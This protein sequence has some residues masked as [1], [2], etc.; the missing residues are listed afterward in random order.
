[1]RRYWNIWIF[2]SRSGTCLL[3]I[4]SNSSWIEIY[5]FSKC[6]SSRFKTVKFIIKYKMWFKNLRFWFSESG[7][8]IIWSC[9][10]V[11]RICKYSFLF[12]LIKHE[13]ISLQVATRWYRAPEI[14]LNARGYNKPI[15][16]WSVGCILGEMLNGK[17]LFPG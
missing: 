16:L 14:M 17:P 10:C 4:V 7:R 3:F 6:T 8:S 9:G 11:D 15:D 13:E 5:S 1:M 12:Q 2:F